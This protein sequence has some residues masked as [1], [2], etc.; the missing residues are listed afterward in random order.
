MELPVLDFSAF[1]DGTSVQRKEL[2]AALLHE[3]KTFGFV[4]LVNHGI[5]NEEIAALFSWVRRLAIYNT[6]RN[7][8][9]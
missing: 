1:S 7:V 2:C 3:C 9:C 6:F 8:L 5:S 4:K